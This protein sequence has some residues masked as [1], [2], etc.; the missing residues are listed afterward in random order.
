MKVLTTYPIPQSQRWQEE[1]TLIEPQANRGPWQ[2]L[3]RLLRPL[4]MRDVL[5]P[6]KLIY[7][8]KD[9]DVLITGA[10]REDC[11]FAILQSLFGGKKIPHLMMC[12]LWKREKNELRHRLKRILLKWMSRSVRKFIVW[13]TDEIEAYSQYFGIPKEQFVFIP[14]HETLSGYSVKPTRGDY[15]FAGGDSSRDY[16]TLLEAVRELDVSVIIASRNPTWRWMVKDLPHVRVESVDPQC[17]R[18][19]MAGSRAVIVPLARGLLQAAGHQ[20]YL[21]AMRLRKPVIVSEAP[22][23]RDHIVHGRTGWIVPA[24]DPIALRRVLAH[25]L[26]DGE[27]VRC[28]TEVAAA[29]VE[30]RFTLEHFVERNLELA[31]TLLL[32]ET[33]SICAATSNHTQS[34]EG[35]DKRQGRELT[36]QP[37]VGGN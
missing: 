37:L 8:R 36:T 7:L 5:L 35:F 30:S 25:I 11:F 14:H 16:A 33:S 19:L 34:A 6:F 2:W 9:Y 22:G 12:C 32:R 1:T 27:E 24:G 21:N 13:S 28:V 26:Q 20:T 17:F 15:L 4:G 10:E 29:D 23:V 3:N 31:K 18:D